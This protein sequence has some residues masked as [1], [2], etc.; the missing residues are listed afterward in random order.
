MAI[1]IEETFQLAAPAEAVW[2]FLLDPARVVTCLPGAELEKVVDE[3]TFEG[4]VKV[5]LGAVGTRYRGRVRLVEV[6]E[7]ARIVRM[8]A[9]G[10]ETGGG[11]A[12]GRLTSQLRE[13]PGGYTEVS[14]TAEVDLTGRVVQVGRG[15]IQGVAKELFGEFARRVQAELEVPDGAPRAVVAAGDDSIPLLRILLRAAWAP[16]ARLL[17]RLFRRP[18]ASPE[19]R[20]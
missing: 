18:P 8:L 11:T 15:M 1:R 12:T 20:P 19:A 14:A 3:R 4:A 10:R 9:E 13:L 17:A 16:I 2:R 5:K 7:G 6:D